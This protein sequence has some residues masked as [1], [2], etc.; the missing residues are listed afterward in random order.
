MEYYVGEV[1]T[2]TY[3]T[4][5]VP[6]ERRYAI[7]TIVHIVDDKREI[8]RYRVTATDDMTITGVITDVF[9]VDKRASEGLCDA[10]GPVEIPV[11]H[12]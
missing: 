5:P 10:L 4:P 7:G 12:N 8:A 1:I 2:C 11:K 6:E 3:A 9:N